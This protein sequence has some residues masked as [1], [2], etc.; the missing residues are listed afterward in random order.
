MP[1]TIGERLLER[2]LTILRACGAGRRECMLFW[3]APGDEPSRIVDVAH[4]PHTA[5]RGSCDIDGDALNSLWRRLAA[6]DLRIVVQV[7]THPGLAY[8]SPT[9]DQFPVIPRAGLLSLVLPDF[10]KAPF[11]PATSFLV[12]LDHDGRWTRLD[13]EEALVWQPR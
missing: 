8:H 11:D 1:V 10:A 5:S 4:L 13:P 7:H 3:L 9:D 6:N 12:R 2:S